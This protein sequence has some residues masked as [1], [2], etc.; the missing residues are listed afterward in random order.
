MKKCEYCGKEISYHQQYCDEKCENNA[1]SF[2]EKRDNFTKIFAVLNGIFVMCIGIGI[3]VFSFSHMTGSIMVTTALLVLGIVYLCL[4]F[5][6][7]IMIHKYKL[8]KAVFITRIIGLSVLL[9]GILALILSFIFV[10]N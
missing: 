8:K 5:P 1:I 4:P 7:E 9:L 2:Y 3:F 6:A 10:F